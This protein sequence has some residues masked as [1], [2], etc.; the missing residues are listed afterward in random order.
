MATYKTFTTVGD[1]G[2]FVSMLILNVGSPVRDADLD[3][4]LFSVYVERKDPETGE[5]VL[6]KEHRAD[7][8]ALPSKGFVPVR[9]AFACDEN[10]RPQDGGTHVALKLPEI[11]L[12]KRIDGDILAGCRLVPSR[13]R[14]RA[15]PP[16]W[17]SCSTSARATSARSS[18]AGTS[19]SPAPSTA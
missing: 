7:P 14:S 13:P 4:A 18:P 15:T 5:V 12:T 16:S 1:S 2:P 11:R 10:G 8:V 9:R 6:A 19:R 3:P 17:A